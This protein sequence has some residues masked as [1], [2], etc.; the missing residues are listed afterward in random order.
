MTATPMQVHPAELWDLMDLLGLPYE[1]HRDD[2][3]FLR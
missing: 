2:G 3:I 1:W